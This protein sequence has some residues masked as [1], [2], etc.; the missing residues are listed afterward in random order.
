V[1]DRERGQGLSGGVDGVLAERQIGWVAED[2]VQDC[3]GLA[4]GGP[5]DLG[6]VGGVV[7]GDVGVGGGALVEE[8]ARQGAGGQAAAALREPL[9]VG[10]RPRSAA[11]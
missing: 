6:A 10:G 3:D 9:G 11:P 2:L 8:V 1:E 7:V 4:P 5:D